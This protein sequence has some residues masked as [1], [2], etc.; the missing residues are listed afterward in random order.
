MA[1]NLNAPGILI[2]RPVQQAQATIDAVSKQG[3]KPIHFPTIEILPSAH[4]DSA[5]ARQMADNADWIIFISQNAVLHFLELVEARSIKDTRIAAVGEATARVL[6]AKG[7]TVMFQP[8]RDFSTEGLLASTEFSDVSGQHVVIVRGN[9]GREKL[10]ETLRQRGAMVSYLEV[11]ER[12]PA[13]SDPQQLLSI[14]PDGIQVIIATSSQLLDNLMTICKDT[15]D[16]QLLSKPV[17]VMSERMLEHARE[18]G[19]ERIWL[20]ERSSN[21]EIIKTISRN[22]ASTQ[23]R[24]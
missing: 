18:L 24:L 10:A 12:H 6:Q 19:F 22:M 11:Y 3:W 20:A 1:E 9:G 17:V 5:N 7:L 8:E 13:D 16:D 15:L 21:D 2:L 23:N 4:I 14:W